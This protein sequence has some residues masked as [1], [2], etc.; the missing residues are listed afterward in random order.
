MVGLHLHKALLFGSPRAKDYRCVF[1]SCL[2]ICFYFKLIQILWFSS[3]S[4]YVFWLLA[5]LAIDGLPP[6]PLPRFKYRPQF[7]LFSGP[8]HEGVYNGRRLL[9]FWKCLFC[10]DNQWI[11]IGAFIQPLTDFPDITKTKTKKKRFHQT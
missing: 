5:F 11:F 3:S 7:F 6:P 2:C 10:I 8:P 4:F 1:P 9:F